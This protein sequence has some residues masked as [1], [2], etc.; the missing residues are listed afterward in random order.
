MDD[1]SLWLCASGLMS[2]RRYDGDRRRILSCRCGTIGVIYSVMYGCFGGMLVCGKC[3]HNI[4]WYRL[5]VSNI[6]T[7]LEV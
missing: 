2:P 6:I 5:I 4:L 7:V 1:P 3:P